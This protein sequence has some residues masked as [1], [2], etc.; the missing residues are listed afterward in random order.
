MSLTTVI[1]VVAMS[2]RAVVVVSVV[3]LILDV[4][5]ARAGIVE[6]NYDNMEHKEVKCNGSMGNME[7]E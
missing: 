6:G 1:V 4:A 5:C 3:I 2:A 7:L